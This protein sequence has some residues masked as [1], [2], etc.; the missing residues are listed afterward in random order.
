MP[1]EPLLAA[2]QNVMLLILNPQLGFVEGDRIGRFAVDCRIVGGTGPL[3]TMPQPAPS[4]HVLSGN[5]S[6]SLIL[7]SPGGNLMRLPFALP[8]AGTESRISCIVAV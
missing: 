5:V 4:S 3:D 6:V 1:F 2:P 8:L 7:I